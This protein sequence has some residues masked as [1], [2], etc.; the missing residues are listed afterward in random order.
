MNIILTPRAR[1]YMLSGVPLLPASNGCTANIII[2]A[3]P[4]PDVSLLGTGVTSY[5]TVQTVLNSNGAKILLEYGNTVTDVRY[6]NTGNIV[7]A[8]TPFASA[9]ASGDATWFVIAFR[10]VNTV[11]GCLTGDVSNYEGTGDLRIGSTL[12]EAGLQYRVNSFSIAM[13]ATLE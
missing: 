11:V 12:V 9:A 7:V 4:K 5:A 6:D 1:T 8:D 3:G 10:Q 13:P 2:G